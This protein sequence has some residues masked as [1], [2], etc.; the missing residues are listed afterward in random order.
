[1][2]DVMSKDAVAVYWDFENI[3]A[4]LF[5]VKNGRGAYSKQSRFAPQDILVDVQAVYDF[6]ATYGDVAINKAYCN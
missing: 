1:M 5:D 4:S 2:E 6:A 3:H